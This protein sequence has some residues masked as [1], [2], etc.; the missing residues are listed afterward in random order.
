VSGGV[1]VALQRPKF[2]LQFLEPGPDPTI[3]L[4]GPRSVRTELG[5]SVA[6]MF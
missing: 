1:A 4:D 3:E 2:L 5:L 6:Q